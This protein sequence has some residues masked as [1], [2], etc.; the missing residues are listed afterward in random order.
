MNDVKWK[1][2]TQYC[3][4]LT[5]APKVFKFHRC[6]F[7]SSIF[8]D[9]LILKVHQVVKKKWCKYNAFP[10]MLLFFCILYICRCIWRLPS[11]HHRRY[12]S[13]TSRIKYA[14][15]NTTKRVQTFI[16]VRCVLIGYSWRSKR[17]RPT[18]YI[19]VKTS[20]CS[21]WI[22]YYQYILLGIKITFDFC[23]F[24]L[25]YLTGLVT[26]R[27]GLEPGRGRIY[28]SMKIWQ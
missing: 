4:R 28:P 2:I 5:H 18:I 12:E 16:H 17:W 10:S 8:W 27:S 20:P 13:L 11:I 6:C 23:L 26:R 9:P 21:W 19:I 15:Y 1:V 25:W 7:I 14:K 24:I 22:N 3:I